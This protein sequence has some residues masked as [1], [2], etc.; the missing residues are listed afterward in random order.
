MSGRGWVWLAVAVAVGVIA[1]GCGS[2]SKSSTTTTNATTT[3]AAGAGGGTSK[4]LV[5]AGSTFVFPLV[6]QWT[7][8]Y[9]KRT[10]VTV[11]YGA[12]GSGGGIAAIIDRSV[13]FGASDAPLSPD[14]QSMCN[15][16]VEIPWALGGTS[17]AYHVSGAPQHL[18]LTGPVLAKI[19]LGHVKSWNDPAIQ[20]L[21]PGA[22]LP[23]TRITAVF[24]SDSSGTSYN[25][26][27]YLA[28]VSS[29]AKSKVGVTTQ[30]AFPTG[31][32]AKGSSGVA[33][34]I[35]NTNGAIGYVDVAYAQQ[36]N[37]AY[38]GIQNAA[39]RYQLPEVATIRAAAAA[40]ASPRPNAAV[41]IVNPPSS[42]PLA[43]PISTFT[44]VIVPT[45]SSKGATMRDFLT[46]AVTTGQSFGPKLLFAPLPPRVV[47]ADKRAIAQIR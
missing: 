22:H 7:A 44:Y 14:Q 39:G 36:N 30:P 21:N 24:R 41:S 33:G 40:A 28:S 16:C 3:S 12:V 37:L 25:F 6:S 31:V 20:D 4:V 27:D 5:G 32:G 15:G 19:Y 17:I 8:D 11:T 2:S 46:Y 29:D 18:R 43:Y 47:A 34:V 45:S 42:A 38:A 23:T 26:T 1:T 10:G 35:K 13:D 9:S